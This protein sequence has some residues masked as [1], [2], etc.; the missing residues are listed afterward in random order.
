[1]PLARIVASNPGAARETALA[2]RQAGYK[3]EIVPPGTPPDSNVELEF[4]ADSDKVISQKEQEDVP[5]RREFVL[6]P[7]WRELTAR[8]HANRDVARAQQSLAHVPAPV[9]TRAVSPS[10][11]QRHEERA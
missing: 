8:Y 9:E 3:V 4:D 1:M 6:K 10:A 11:P 5:G 7:L 2:L